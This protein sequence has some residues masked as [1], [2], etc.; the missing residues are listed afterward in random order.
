MGGP[1]G[2][3]GATFGGNVGCGVPVGRGTTPGG[4]GPGRDI[5]GEGVVEGNGGDWA[6]GV[7]LG[8]ELVIETGRFRFKF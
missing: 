5:G 6:N 8:A 1:V 4:G 3:P 2:L 7:G